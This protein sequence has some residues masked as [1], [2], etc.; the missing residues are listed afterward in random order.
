MKSKFLFFSLV[1]ALAILTACGNDVPHETL[2]P[3]DATVFRSTMEAEGYEVYDL[4][5]ERGEESFAQ[6]H[7][8]V[9]GINYHFEFAEVDTADRAIYAFD[10]RR[11]ILESTRMTELQDY[12]VEEHSGANYSFFQQQ[13]SSTFLYL[14]RIDNTLLY[15]SAHVQYLEYVESLID[16]IR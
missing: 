5:A 7:L 1:L 8:L 2:P 9:D 3:W 13:S 15:V 10:S 14:H 12:F 16:K 11:A 4:I 6:N